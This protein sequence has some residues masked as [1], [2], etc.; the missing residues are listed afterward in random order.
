M[1]VIS[2]THQFQPLTK[3]SVAFAGQRLIR[4]IAKADRN[5]KYPSPHLVDSLCVSVP[6]I[7]MDTVAEY[8][9]RFIPHIISM[10]ESV[11][12]KIAR[13]YRIESGRNEITQAQL[14]I[15]AILGYLDAD[16]AGSRV[17]KEYLQEWFSSE[18]SAIAMDWIRDISGGTIADSVA[19]AKCEVLRDMFAGYSSHKYS[20]NIPSLK[21]VLRF[22]DHC[23]ALDAADSRMIS[24]RDKAHTQ[25]TRK[26][27]EM[28]MDALGF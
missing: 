10:C 5:G 2:S 17:S 1:S 3:T 7:D 19:H 16:A 26:E 20:P 27:S 13:E 18:Y 12:D 6:R 23:I 25:L 28:N 11:Q 4:I 9:E 24:I 8:I 15:D 21:A 14:D 22:S